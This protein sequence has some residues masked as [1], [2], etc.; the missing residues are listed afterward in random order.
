MKKRKPI[1]IAPDCVRPAVARGV[2]G[3]CGAAARAEINA[4]TITE[5]ELIQRG[6]LLPRRTRRGPMKRAIEDV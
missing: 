1:C 4:G 3:P 5:R 6:L 2:C